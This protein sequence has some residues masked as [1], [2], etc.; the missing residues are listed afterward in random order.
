MARKP[1]MFVREVTPGRHPLGYRWA[2][3][4]SAFGG[5]EGFTESVVGVADLAG[6]VLSDDVAFGG[7]LVEAFDLSLAVR[8]GNAPV[9]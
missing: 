4:V 7:V 6:D 8:V 5:P 1:E 2:F 3:S 9:A